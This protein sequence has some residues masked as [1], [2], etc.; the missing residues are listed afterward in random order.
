MTAA[1]LFVL[2]LVVQLVLALVIVAAFAFVVWVLWDCSAGPSAR[3][4]AE[5]RA[6]AR[7]EVH[8]R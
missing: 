4:A 2:T 8:G 5:A 7:R 1:L 6:R 3:L